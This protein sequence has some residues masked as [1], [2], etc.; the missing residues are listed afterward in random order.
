MTDSVELGRDWIIKAFASHLSD[1]NQR[2][3][4]N[5]VQASLDKEI[6]G[7]VLTE[8][9]YPLGSIVTAVQEVKGKMARVI[10]P[11]TEMIV[12][13]SLDVPTGR[14]HHVVHFMDG[15]KTAFTRMWID[16]R[17]PVD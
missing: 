7:G 14:V 6:D 9:S 13:P 16:N 15:D 8:R 2:L 11:E 17:N 3:I 4:G 12:I 10:I 5:M 1:D